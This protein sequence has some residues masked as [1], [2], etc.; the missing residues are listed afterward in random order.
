MITF[1]EILVSM[2]ARLHTADVFEEV[3][4]NEIIGTL[5]NI[6]ERIRITQNGIGKQAVY[7]T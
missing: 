7:H 4:I 3:V 1:S 2:V 6:S 5:G